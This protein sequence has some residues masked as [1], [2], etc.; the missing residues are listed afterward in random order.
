MKASRL[1]LFAVTA[2]VLLSS[3][4]K[5]FYF[6]NQPDGKS[7]GRTSDKGGIT[8]SH[9]DVTVGTGDWQLGTDEEGGNYLFASIPVTAIDAQV[10]RDG[11]V[12]VSRGYTDDEGYTVWTPLPMVR[13]QALNYGT[14]EEFLY[15]EYLDFEWSEGFVFIYFTATDLFVD[16][17]PEYWPEF[18]LRV[19]VWR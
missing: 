8:M 14:N 6:D 16:D 9:Y 17:D 13:A 7:S 12:T 10:V 4:T 11:M 15:S 1:F 5:E 2:V 19:T 18:S 3:C